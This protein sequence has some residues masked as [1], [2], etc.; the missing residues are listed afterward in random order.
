M[1]GDCKKR[2]AVQNC[3]N[4]CQIKCKKANV[5]ALECIIK[6]IDG[7]GEKTNRNQKGMICPIQCISRVPH[8]ER[9]KNHGAIHQTTAP[10]HPSP[11]WVKH[12]KRPVLRSQVSLKLSFL[13]L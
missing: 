7:Q 8:L 9:R 13:K 1:V 6:A 12:H 10:R 5:L 4:L 3:L 2:V 11:R